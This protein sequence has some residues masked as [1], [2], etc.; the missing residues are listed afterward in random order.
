M[1]IRI[2]KYLSERKIL[3]RRKA[4]D[5][6][7]KGWIRVNGQVVTQLGTMVD[8]FVD[9]VTVDDSV[10]RMQSSF[11]C[12]AYYKPRGIVTNLPQGDE[13]EIRDLLPNKYK[14]L[15]P[16]GR[17]DKESE[18]L[19][20]L[21]DDGVLA[22]EILQGHPP[23]K[24]TYIVTLSRTLTE[25]MMTRLRDGVLMLGKKTQPIS[26]R[27]LGKRRYEIIM[28]E[29]KNRQI[30]RMMK[31]LSVDVLILKRVKIGSLSLDVSVGQWREISSTERQAFL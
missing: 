30:R 28:V 20:L 16:I 2:Q 31:K 13:R 18:G 4:E 21:T 27:S 22:R 3:S 25:G 24:R 11:V 23:H 1:K 9:K 14:K 29:G 26:I 10:K 5:C 8:P 7:K 12:L 6:L 19:I 15:S 17:L